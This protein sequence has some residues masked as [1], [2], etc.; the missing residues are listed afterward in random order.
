M[1]LSQRTY[2]RLSH[3]RETWLHS[4]PTWHGMGLIKVSHDS[5]FAHKAWLNM[6]PVWQKRPALNFSE[7]LFN[8]AIN[9]VNHSPPQLLFSSAV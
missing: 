2:R 8:K 7:E 5:P 4:Y 6:K 9:G 1:W 3:G